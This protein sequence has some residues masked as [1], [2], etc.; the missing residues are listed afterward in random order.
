M[1]E[2]D[3]D[4]FLHRKGRTNGDVIR[5]APDEEI[6][7]W[8]CKGRDCGRCDFEDRCYPGHNGALDWLKS[9]A[10]VQRGE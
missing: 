7:V 3:S 1:A 6:A 5:S 8:Y 10:E 2:Y 4:E 9:R